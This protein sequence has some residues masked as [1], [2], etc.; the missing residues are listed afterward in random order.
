[1]NAAQAIPEG[2]ADTNEIRIV[3]R[4][5][6]RGRALVEISDTGSGIPDEIARQLFVPFV[7]TKPVGVGTGLGLS[8]CQRIVTSLGGEIGFDT[9]VGR[10]STFRVSLPVDTTAAA[11]PVKSGPP[12]K[13]SSARRRIAVIDD[14]ITIGN[15]MRRILQRDHE[16]VVFADASS[17]LA[18]FE[19]DRA[20]D[21]IFC[22]LMMPVVN[23]FEFH[24]RVCLVAP[25]LAERTVFLTGGAFTDETRQFLDCVTNLSITKPFEIAALRA[26][27]AERVG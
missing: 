18:V 21:L 14:D 5:D 2:R 15:L 26:L 13:K 8:I 9:Q 27:V 19:H 11:P 4:L 23:G 20:F 3:V 10:G 1:V 22:D 12:L 24:C 16:V 7:T 17:A 25:E 6:E